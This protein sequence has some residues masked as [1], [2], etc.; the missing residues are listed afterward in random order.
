MNCFFTDAAMI[1]GWQVSGLRENIGKP[2]QLLA[3]SVL[4]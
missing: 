2:T 3:I 1:G 4:A